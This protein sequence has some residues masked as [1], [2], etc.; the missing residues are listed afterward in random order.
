MTYIIQ[1]DLMS[2]IIG[3]LIPPIIVFLC[4]MAMV[5]TR[6]INTFVVGSYVTQ[7]VYRNN[8]LMKENKKLREMYENE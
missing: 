4:G 8:E 1:I 5:F 2:A 7:T 3:V 6:R